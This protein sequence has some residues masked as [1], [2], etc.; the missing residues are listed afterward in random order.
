MKKEIK[1]ILPLVM[2]AF[3]FGSTMTQAA[4]GVSIGNTFTYDVEA[5]SWDVTIDT[6]SSSGT[7]FNFLDVTRAVGS[8]F[9]IEVTAVDP[10]SVDWDM[11]IGT[12]SDSGAS[13]PFD[14]LGVIFLTFFPLL[15]IDAGS[16]SW[17]QAE[18]DLG[19]EIM[20]FFFA[21]PD[22]FA[23][24]FTALVEENIATYYVTDPEFNFDNVGG[25]FDNDTDIAVFEWHFDLTYY[26]NGSENFAGDFVWQYAYDQTDG[27][28]KGNYMNMDYSGT[29]GGIDIIYKLEQRVEE[30]GYNLPNV[31]AGILPGFEWFIAIPIVA[32]LGGITIINRKRKA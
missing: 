26:V 1:I 18:M 13:S 28:M 9:E 4:Y 22:T 11:T 23:E 16:M 3:L 31:N 8:Q 20:S 6:S 29:I 17:N 19:L 15:I 5:A 27:H 12:D 14:A 32:L 30:E 10:T 7:G 24:I 21:E 25:T 2:V